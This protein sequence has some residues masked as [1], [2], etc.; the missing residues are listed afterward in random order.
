MDGEPV[1]STHA[2]QLQ[3]CAA[4][5]DVPSRKPIA[6]RINSS[7]RRSPNDAIGKACSQ[8]PL[9][10]A[11]T[12]RRRARSRSVVA[13][14][15]RMADACSMEAR[16][17]LLC[18]CASSA[19]GSVAEYR[20]AQI[21]RVWEIHGSSSTVVNSKMLDCRFRVPAAEAK[22]AEGASRAALRIPSPPSLTGR[23]ACIQLTSDILMLMILESPDLSSASNR[24]SSGWSE[25][26]EDRSVYKSFGVLRADFK[27]TNASCD[28]RSFR[29]SMA[30]ARSEH[31][32]DNAWSRARPGKI[33]APSKLASIGWTLEKSENSSRSIVSAHCTTSHFDTFRFRPIP[34]PPE[35]SY[36]GRA[37]WRTRLRPDWHHPGSPSAAHLLGLSGWNVTLSIITRAPWCLLAAPPRE[38]WSACLPIWDKTLTRKRGRRR[39][40]VL[41][42][43]RIPLPA[44]SHDGENWRRLKSLT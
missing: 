40:A 32:T 10:G 3:G 15:S 38:K 2:P 9:W 12:A 11:A 26:G 25:Q 35:R 21:C 14:W 6:T 37:R 27:M 44:W 20:A 17:Q 5:M 43:A 30:R 4:Q 29:R 23:L 19:D 31:R 13:C 33:G 24:S 28:E 16:S 41:E 42:A 1:L 22:K 8:S 34:L 39:L 18:R 7:S 36:G